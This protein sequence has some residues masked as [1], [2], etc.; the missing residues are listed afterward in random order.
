MG[1]GLPIQEFGDAGNR[2]IISKSKTEMFQVITQ[3]EKRGKV[4]LAEPGSL[5]LS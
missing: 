2:R 5:K 3:R 1:I 4:A